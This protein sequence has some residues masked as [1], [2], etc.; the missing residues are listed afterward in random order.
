MHEVDKVEETRFG[1]R[2]TVEGAINSPDGRNPSVRAVWFV[3][4]NE[5]APHLVTAYP[6]QEEKP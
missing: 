5:T 1:M 3:R 4:H 2:Y 6:Y